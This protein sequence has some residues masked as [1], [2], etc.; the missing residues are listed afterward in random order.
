V[1]LFVDQLW[2]KVGYGRQMKRS[3]ALSASLIIGF[4]L[5]VAM[6]DLGGAERTRGRRTMAALLRQWTRLRVAAFGSSV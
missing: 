4:E 1:V 5:N 3:I 2:E 6:S